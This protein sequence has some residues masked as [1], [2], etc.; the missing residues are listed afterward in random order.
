M[1][2]VIVFDFTLYS[3]VVRYVKCCVFSVEI[4]ADVKMF[5]KLIFIVGRLIH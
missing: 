1:C 3:L 5:H 2:L 4:A